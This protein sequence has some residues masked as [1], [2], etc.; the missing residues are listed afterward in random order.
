MN[1][2]PLVSVLLA[3]RDGARYLEQSLAS[4]AAQ[5]WSEVELVLVDDGSHDRTPAILAE[6]AASRPRAVVVRTEGVGLAGALARAADQASGDLL[7]RQDD[8]DRSHPERLAR[9]VRFLAGHPEVAVAGTFASVLDASGTRIGA[10]EVPTDPERM[11]AML[12]RAPPFVHGSVMMRREVYR[13]AG[14][15]RGAFRASQ[16]LDLWMRLPPGTGIANLAE[17]LYEWRRHPGGVFTRARD[18]QLFYA[19]VARA[20]RDERAATGRDS[21]DLLAKTGSPEAFLAAYAFAPRLARYLGEALVREGRPAEARRHLARAMESG[22]ERG[23]ALQWWLLSWPVAL[24]SRARE[25][26]G[27]QLPNGAGA[28]PAESRR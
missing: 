17:P 20:F 8:D 10:Y 11:R 7:A 5:T 14:G 26:R 1:E 16:D 19:A 28:R 13:R 27:S 9:Q 12:R 23:A 18:Q 25:A 21:V 22:E 4:L 6:F 24:T 2:K 15:Y 3:S